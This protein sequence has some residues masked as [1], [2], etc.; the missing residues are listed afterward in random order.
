[1]VTISILFGTVQMNNFA[2]K[3]KRLQNLFFRSYKLQSIKCCLHLKECHT[4]LTTQ[5]HAKSEKHDLTGLY[6]ISLNF[7]PIIKQKPKH[8]PYL[9][10]SC[11]T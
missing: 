10:S 3:F 4:T 9:G 7:A 1:M 2:M 11:L 5:K 8:Q 6:K